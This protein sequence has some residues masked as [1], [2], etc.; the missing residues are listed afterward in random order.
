M[1][2]LGGRPGR[3]ERRSC[4]AKPQ[5][6]W[7]RVL[8]SR[9]RSTGSSPPLILLR[10]P[11][12]RERQL[13]VFDP[14]AE[15]RFFKRHTL[16][17]VIVG[18]S[19]MPDPIAQGS[20]A[21]VWHSVQSEDAGDGFALVVFGAVRAE[22]VGQ[23]QKSLRERCG[24]ERR[25]DIQSG[26]S[27]LNGVRVRVRDKEGGERPLAGRCSMGGPDSTHAEQ[28][29]VS[30]DFGLD[31]PRLWTLTARMSLDEAWR[32]FFNFFLIFCW[33]LGTEESCI[34]ACGQLATLAFLGAR[35]S[36]GSSKS[37]TSPAQLFRSLTART[38][39][40]PGPRP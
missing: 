30:V 6:G 36:G 7:R 18:Q 31:P 3:E 2:P 11:F 40:Y 16:G 13:A 37:S 12:E 9:P 23:T 17:V 28:D 34:R 24:G 4:A 5:V 26:R 19:A 20:N 29:V 15:V 14:E 22:G 35:L 32:Y 21:A 10:I 38:G 25:V 1:P 27:V 8:A 39:R 33:A